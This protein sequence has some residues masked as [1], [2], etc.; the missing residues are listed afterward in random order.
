VKVPRCVWPCRGH[1][2]QV[3]TRGIG[4]GSLMR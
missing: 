1:A 2:P 3:H 4:L